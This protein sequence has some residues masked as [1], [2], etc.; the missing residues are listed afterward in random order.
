MRLA[1]TFR[2]LLVLTL[3]ACGGGTA[4]V[5]DEGGGA[6][7]TSGGDV[8]EAGADDAELDPCAEGGA[9][10]EGEATAE[11]EA[12]AEGSGEGERDMPGEGEG[13]GDGETAEGEAVAGDAGAPL[14]PE[15]AW[16]AKV[17]LGGQ[18]FRRRCDNCHP[19]GEEDIGP[20]LRGIR[21]AVPRMERQIRRGSGRM[22]P[23]PPRRLSA[24]NMDAVMAY[25]SRFRAVR[26]VQRPE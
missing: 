9:P 14:D 21:W 3:T 23:I 17:R 1:G 4:D 8:A 24:E 20:N 2:L 10:C 12:G 19:G 18:W 13:E 22:R 15:E 25:M 11:G 5:A 26:G 6:D 16:R 7:G